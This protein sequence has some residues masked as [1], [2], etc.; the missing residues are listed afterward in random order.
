MK[1]LSRV[2]LCDPVDCNVLEALIPNALVTGSSHL[3]LKTSVHPS[4][5]LTALSTD[6][7]PAYPHQSSQLFRQL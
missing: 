1:S 7:V 6:P 2:R 4:P 3:W 5:L